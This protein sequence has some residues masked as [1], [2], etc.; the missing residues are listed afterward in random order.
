M[1]LNDSTIARSRRTKHPRISKRIE[2]PTILRSEQKRDSVH[3]MWSQETVWEKKMKRKR[4]YWSVS[5]SIDG[6]DGESGR[7]AA[8]GGGGGGERV[9]DIK[10]SWL[11][12][13]FRGSCAG[14]SGCVLKRGKFN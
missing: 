14:S 12:I 9:S 13:S 2:H 8:G 5:R 6:P 7:A 11:E 10:I 4:K 3:Y 1:I